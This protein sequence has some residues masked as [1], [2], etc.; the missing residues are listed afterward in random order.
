MSL[1]T[2][3]L[4]NYNVKEFTLGFQCPENFKH[5]IHHSSLASCYNDWEQ[6]NSTLTGTTK[7]SRLFN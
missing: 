6:L 3:V 2:I 1:P 7:R 4:C 5:L